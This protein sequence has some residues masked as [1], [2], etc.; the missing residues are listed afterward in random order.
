MTPPAKFSA[1]TS[2]T[3]TSLFA[4]SAAYGRLRSSVMLR[5]PWLYWLK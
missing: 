3:A 4:I 2:L 1:A 5:F